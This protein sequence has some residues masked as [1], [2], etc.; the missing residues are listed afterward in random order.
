MKHFY[1]ETEREEKMWME[2]MVGDSSNETLLLSY[3]LPKTFYAH[4]TNFPR[5]LNIA[6]MSLNGTLSENVSEA[7]WMK[8]KHGADKSAIISL[9]RGLALNNQQLVGFL[10]ESLAAAKAAQLVRVT[11]TKDGVN[12]WFSPTVSEVEFSPHLKDLLNAE[13][14]LRPAAAPNDGLNVKVDCL[15]G[16]NR[17]TFAL[18]SPQCSPNFY[19][20][21]SERGVLALLTLEFASDGNV[22]LR[23]IIAS[24][25]CAVL[26][27]AAV[28]KI[29]YHLYPLRNYGRFAIEKLEVKVITSSV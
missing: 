27:L 12:L 17:L 25:P 13:S 22:S 10:N 11:E 1:A 29:D 15:R 7:F 5:H 26:P 4:A 19:I 20:N 21:Q 3:A 9:K 23:E 18:T 8:V 16:L 24:Q 6:H 28:S 2:E 14:P